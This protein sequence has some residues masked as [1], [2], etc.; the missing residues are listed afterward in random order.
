MKMS[1]KSN[2]LKFLLRMNSVCINTFVFVSHS[3]NN[4]K[5]SADVANM[6]TSRNQ[7]KSGRS[8]KY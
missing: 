1:N 3:D 4:E 5:S 7:G 6:F 2:K 8:F